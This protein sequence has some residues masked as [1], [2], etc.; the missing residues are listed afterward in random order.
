MRR[1]LFAIPI[2]A[3]CI[4]AGAQAQVK[5]E[6]KRPE[7]P[8]VTRATT[9][10]HQVLTI[11]GQNVETNVEAEERTRATASK[12][13]ADGS[14]RVEEKTESVKLN[15]DTPAGKLE[16]D[17][18]KPAASKNENPMLDAIQNAM[19]ARVG[20]SYTYVFGPDGKVKA[21]EGT[22]KVIQSAPGDVQEILKQELDPERL[23]R[24]LNQDLALLPEKAVNKGDRWQ[25]TVTM[26]I[27]AGQTLTFTEYLEY[28]G[29]VE[30]DGKTLDKISVY[31]G[32]VKYDLDPNSPLPVKV[33][34]SDLK[35]DSSSGTVLFDRESGQIV[36]NSGAVR[37]V[38]PMTFSVNGM[39]LPGK[40]DL[41]I[42]MS[43][44]LAR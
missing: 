31:T 26:D 19:K 7:G 35:I 14:I 6:R 24:R 39:E 5:L 28:Q 9:K 15:L 33:T 29:T 44:A 3:F 11:A 16:F 40:L 25:R 20:K 4:Q 32:E 38:G 21:V 23:K 18:T 36:E 17:S 22:E 34:H 12:P 10:M 2:L 37:I 41:T 27:G 43:S 42:D 1:L 30:K 8:V 13:A